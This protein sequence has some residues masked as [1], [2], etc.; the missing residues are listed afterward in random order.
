VPVSLRS[1]L[2]YLAFL[3]I[4]V[5][6]I[7]AVLQSG[8]GLTAE[9]VAPHNGAG[10][11]VS[12]ATLRVLLAQI[13]VTLIA[14]YGLGFVA[15]WIGQPSVIGELAGGIVLGPTILG[16]LWPAA[17]QAIFPADSLGALKL[18]ADVGVIFFMFAVGL[19]VDLDALRGATHRAVV[20]SHASIAIP[21]LL[22]VVSALALHR[23][24]APAGT[25]FVAFALFIGIAMAI[26]A[27]PVLARILTER[28]MA[29]TPLGTTALTCAAVDDITAWGLLSLVVAIVRGRSRADVVMMVMLTIVFAAAMLRVVRPLLARVRAGDATLI[30]LMFASAAITEAIGIHAVFGAFLAGVIVPAAPETRRRYAER[31]S[32]VTPALLPLFFVYVG[33]RTELTLIS[34]VST[35]IACV[36]ILLVATAGKLGGSALAGR[37]T[38]MAWRDALA[39]GAL[40]NT[41]GLME[42]IAVNIAYDLGILTPSMFAILV[43]MALVAT[44][45][46]GP[47]LTLFTSS[48]APKHSMPGGV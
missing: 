48:G 44:I 29:A 16:H 22:G 10:S 3:C 18:L 31:L 46:T 7:F 47:L 42:L 13:V 17:Y 37:I 36:A 21:F 2:A 9:G 26:T 23:I 27:F 5:A 39:L 30:L 8:R 25:P 20:I 28:G 45:A 6:A 32:I 11:V 15:R 14:A 33:V 1:V 41:R 24:F 4:F 38:G 40:M 34:S 19:E 12:A 43:V 35:A